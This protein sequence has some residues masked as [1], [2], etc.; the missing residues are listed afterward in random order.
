M[1]YR[2]LASGLIAGFAAGLFAALLHFAFTQPLLLLGEQYE[3]GALTHFGMQGSHATAT[4]DAPAQDQIGTATVEGDGHGMTGHAHG[5]ASSGD[6]GAFK[7]NALTV[8]FMGFTY[9]AYGLL[10]AAGY[11]LAAHLGHAVTAERGLLWGLGGFVA[12]HMAPALGLAPELPGTIGAELVHRQIWWLLTVVA[13]AVAI[14]LFAAGRW[15][16]WA[17]VAAGALLA[18][19]HGIGAPMIEGFYGSAPPELAAAYSARALGVALA[20]WLVLGWL[21]AKLWTQEAR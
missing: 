12:F 7:R 5:A 1:T 18:L 3:M 2:M 6:E 4:H 11:G 14:G 9:A 21:S 17:W 20:A 13:T 15:G 8:L 16:V 19:P 10:L